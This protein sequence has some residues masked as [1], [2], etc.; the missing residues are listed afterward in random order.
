MH[1]R[2]SVA[3]E[4]DN[5][6][7][8]SMC[9]AV[10]DSGDSEATTIT[11]GTGPSLIFGAELEI[12]TSASPLHGCQSLEHPV[13]NHPHIPHSAAQEPSLLSLANAATRSDRPI[14]AMERKGDREAQDADER[15]SGM[16][17]PEAPSGAAS[18][19][20]SDG[21]TIVGSALVAS[22]LRPHSVVAPWFPPSADALSFGI[23]AAGSSSAPLRAT[24]ANVGP[25]AAGTA[26]ALDTSPLR[27]TTGRPRNRK[28][29]LTLVKERGGVIGPPRRPVSGVGGKRARCLVH[30]WGNSGRPTETRA[31]RPCAVRAAFDAA[32]ASDA[33]ARGATELV[34][35]LARSPSLEAYW[36]P[37]CLL[38]G[39]LSDLARLDRLKAEIEEMESAGPAAVGGARAKRLMRELSKLF[40]PATRCNA[41]A[42][43]RNDGLCRCGGGRL[44]R[45]CSAL[46]CRTAHPYAGLDFCDGCGQR[47]RAC[48]CA[49]PARP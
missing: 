25:G 32:A 23:A 8:S 24:A 7:A 14:R 29:T 34:R 42:G 16:G 5:T 10:A 11:V 2:G 49:A 4:T 22:T 3:V 44:W 41:H 31:C 13:V 33:A 1:D 27:G 21:E 20:P 43:R 40:S 26:A 38:D 36:C 35:R 37:F 9:I 45:E 19:T 28:A 12:H 39:L 48:T 17:S 30:P 46:G 47:M 6:P 15:P 18:T